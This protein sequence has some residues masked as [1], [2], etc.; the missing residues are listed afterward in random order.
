MPEIV[1]RPIACLPGPELQAQTW[2]L[3][4]LASPNGHPTRTIT[5]KASRLVNEAVRPKN[6]KPVKESDVMFV[7]PVQRLARIS[8]S[9][10]GLAC[11][12]VQSFVQSAS[13]HMACGEVVRRCKE[14][15]SQLEQKF[16]E[17]CH[18]QEQRAE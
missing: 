10:A 4:A 11:L 5:A 1:L 16:P 18:S 14:V 8:T 12:H 15:M 3:V 6:S 7:R 13:I 17:L 2:R 9:D